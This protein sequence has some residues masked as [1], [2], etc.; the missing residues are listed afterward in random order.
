MHSNF[1]F[2]F[3]CFVADQQCSVYSISARVD[4]PV[5]GVRSLCNGWHP[6]A[7]VSAYRGWTEFHVFSCHPQS[8]R[9]IA[10]RIGHSLGVYGRLFTLLSKTLLSQILPQ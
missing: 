1:V 2:N 5:P 7:V 9:T 10:R 3:V 4:V 6:S 8:A